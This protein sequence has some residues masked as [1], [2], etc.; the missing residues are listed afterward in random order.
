[1]K[2]L[3]LGSTGMLGSMVTHYLKNKTEHD[4]YGSCSSQLFHTESSDC[5]V[6]IALNCFRDIEKALR[7]IEDG[8]YDYI[9]NC[10]GVIKQR[11]CDLTANE[12]EKKSVL[13]NALFP[14]ALTE[15]QTTRV[16]QIATDCVY[17]GKAGWYSES[18]E[19]DYFDTYAR[20]KSLGEVRS[21]NLLNIRCSII[22]PEISRHLSLMDWFLLNPNQVV[23]GY[24]DHL[25]NGVT[26][27]QFAQLCAEIIEKGSFEKLRDL[28]HTIHYVKNLP[29][30]KYELLMIC[31]DVFNREVIVNPVFSGYPINRTLTSIYMNNTLLDMRIAVEDLSSYMKE[32]STYYP[33]HEVL[34]NG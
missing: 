7:V 22:G 23:N 8:N 11:S 15:I 10:I 1:M 3:V 28:N 30:S 16:L 2:I 34:L 26:T 32:Y 4:V 19:A 21:E 18:D 5:H 12:Y 9:I 13:V 6:K 27:L 24:I 29:V 25:W 14:N 20:T 31:K 17:S 33:K